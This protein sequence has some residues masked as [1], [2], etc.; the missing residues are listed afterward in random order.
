MTASDPR[1]ARAKALQLH[2]VVAHWGECR[3]AS[4]LE[5]LL[6]WEE[7]E[8]ARRSLERRLRCAHIGR[9]KPLADFDWHWPEQCDQAA[10]A[11][12]M[13]LEFLQTATNAILVGPSGLGKTTIAQ[14]LAHQAVLRG[15]T[16]LFTTAGQLLGELAALDSDSALRRRLRHY[17]APALLLIDE[18][19]YLSYSNRHAD[20]LFE[21]I[22]RR[23]EKKSTLIT[24]NKS[25]AE[26]SEVFPNAACVVALI[27][28]LVHHAE[29]IALKGESFRHKEAQERAAAN[30][31]KRKS[32][33]SPA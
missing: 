16:V 17:A 30:A 33:R 22:S 21:L 5:P 19:G 32:A 31:R 8:R 24:T 2:G 29:I 14:N 12:L 26:W 10:I 20:L 28:R 3:E 23:H 1:L 7:A 27:D 15:H 4:W 13:T 9:F 11:E 18:V 25:F 6:A